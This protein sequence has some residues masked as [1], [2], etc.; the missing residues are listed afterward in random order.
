ME[1]YQYSLLSS[2]LGIMIVFL[3]LIALS[4][5]MVLLKRVFGARKVKRAEV[6]VEESSAPVV[7]QD[8]AEE[9]DWLS[10][11]VVAYLIE[12]AEALEAPSASGWTPAADER[13]D[14]WV[15]VPRL[16]TNV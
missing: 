9:L 12:E 3:A 6:P 2:G 1:T 10:A 15:S 16:R 4:V 7:Q 11:A 8:D 5:M 13:T 14:P